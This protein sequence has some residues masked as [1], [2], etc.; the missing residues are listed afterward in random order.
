[1]PEVIVGAGSGW[2]ARTVATLVVVTVLAGLLPGMAR[3]ADAA[4]DAGVAV[5][6]E[7]R[8]L[9]GLR[10]VTADAQM[11]K[12]A[13]AHS[14]YMV[15][16]GT[17]SHHEDPSSPHYTK[18]GDQA[19]R[20]SNLKVSSSASLSARAAVNSLMA[21]PFHGV[22]FLDP[23]LGRSGGGLHND[24][25]AS[26][27][28]SGYTINVLRG[29]AS[30]APEGT[31]YPIVWPGHGSTV[32]LDRYSGNELPDPLTSCPG[33]KAPTGLPLIVQFG[34]AEPVRS[35]KA[36]TAGST[37]AACVFDGGSYRNPDG[38]SQST[39]RG[40]LAARNA[41]IVIPKAP[42]APGKVTVE[43]TT[44][45][46]TVRWTFTVGE[47]NVPKT[48]APK[49]EAPK[50]GMTTSETPTRAAATPPVRSIEGSCP[51]GRVPS[52][53]YRDV[54]I[55][56]THRLAVDCVTWWEVSRGSSTSLYRP[57][58]AVTRGQMATF[59]ARSIAASG[60]SLPASP[61]SLFRDTWASHHEHAINQLAEVGI[62]GGTT[63]DRFEP[64]EVVTRAQMATFLV[65]AYE[66][67]S[68][69][70]AAVRGGYFHDTAGSPHARMIDAA[71]TAGF[72]GGRSPGYY[73]P[74]RPVQRAA[75]ATFVA[76]V[77]DRLVDEG[78]ARTP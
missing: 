30:A 47:H 24:A 61:R 33:F 35:A 59:I 14:R 72:A 16:T 56:S 69:R 34:A 17:I 38:A 18:A 41:A 32:A 54:P 7:M 11:A 73:A 25:S 3:P 51:E 53:G 49:K 64:D 4:G 28:R 63:A 65:R 23:R 57:A 5:V 66:Y 43:L 44:S 40:A 37:A 26:R 62:V 31:R 27:W 12:D 2:R 36:T 74:E 10:P 76:R 77:L 45:K 60:G 67:R 19:A 55:G 6:N 21:A 29:R 9:A 68:G 48:E 78:A 71:A 1:M 13:A 75:M 20:E 15:R 39:G 58:A 8:A 50:T 46:Q 70:R 22:G 42:L 52:A